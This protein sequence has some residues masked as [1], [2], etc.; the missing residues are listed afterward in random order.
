MLNHWVASPRD[1]QVELVADPRFEPTSAAAHPDAEIRMVRTAGLEP[2]FPFEKQIFVPPRLLPPPN[3]RSDYPFAIAFRLYAPGGQNLTQVALPQSPAAL[4][5]YFQKRGGVIGLPA[6]RPV[7]RLP[8]GRSARRRHHRR[9]E[10]HACP[11]QGGRGDAFLLKSARDR[12]GG[13]VPAAGLE[14]A[15][16]SRASGF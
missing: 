6:L 11:N 12:V 9:R 4:I 14:P 7:A 8:A 15:R 13:L 2:A 1:S 16:P 10:R 5:E 3:W